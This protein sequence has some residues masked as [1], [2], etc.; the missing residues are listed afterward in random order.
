M[1]ER[2]SFIQPFRNRLLGIFN[3]SSSGQDPY[4]QPAYTR[5]PRRRKTDRR[6]DGNNWELESQ[7]FFDDFISLDE[8]KITHGLSQARARQ[9]FD[10]KFRASSHSEHLAREM[11]ILQDTLATE[12]VAPEITAQKLVLLDQFRQDFE[13]LIKSRLPLLNQRF[14]LFSLPILKRLKSWGFQPR[15]LQN[16]VWLRCFSICRA[17][18]LD[19]S[20]ALMMAQLSLSYLEQPARY[21][22]MQRFIERHLID[23]DSFESLIRQTLHALEQNFRLFE[24]LAQELELLSLQAQPWYLK[25]TGRP[26]LDLNKRL[27]R[28]HLI[29]RYQNL[30]NRLST[31]TSPG[32]NDLQLLAEK[33]SLIPDWKA[34]NAALE[35][36]ISLTQHPEV[37][38]HER[39]SELPGLSRHETTFSLEQLEHIQTQIQQQALHPLTE[40]LQVYVSPLTERQLQSV[41]EHDLAI[42]EK[43]SVFKAQQIHLFQE[44]V[45]KKVQQACQDVRPDL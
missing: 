42:Q 24:V 32:K 5:P 7:N 10:R 11:E 2:D 35:A 3:S 31:K 36:L 13:H 15:M 8:E 23:L 45:L 43:W 22:D 16:L 20:E 25:Q 27:A 28:R 9:A 37:P 21:S 40:N 44:Q 17:E 4:R 6:A 19:N 38:A 29:N 18:M 1:N 34:F 12:G 33:S 26:Y 14:E 41:C 39:L 30:Y